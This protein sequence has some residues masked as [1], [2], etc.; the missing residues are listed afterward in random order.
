L[1]D[2][3]AVWQ[4]P[5]DAIFLPPEKWQ[6]QLPQ[7]SGVTVLTLSRFKGAPVNPTVGNHWWMAGGEDTEL[8]PYLIK[9]RFT[10]TSRGKIYHKN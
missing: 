3:V 7:V 6:T 5:V 2:D 1:I 10:G 8:V 9:G 4:E